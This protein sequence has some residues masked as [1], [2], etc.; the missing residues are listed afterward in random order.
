MGILWR[1]LGYALAQIRRRP[2]LY[3]GVIVSLAL[4]IG[5]N[6]TIFSYADALLLRL[7]AVSHP[8]SLAEVYTHNT[9]PNAA[10]GGLYPLSYLDYKDIRDLN[11]SFSGLAIYDPLAQV[12]M[13]HGEGAQGGPRTSWNLQLVSGN[14]FTVLGV[15]PILGRAILPQEA[16]TVGTSAV[17]VLAYRTW[18]EQFGG[19]RHILG[20]K[21][22]LNQ[23]PYI[24]VGVAPADFDGLISGVQTDAWAPV[25]MAVRTG[26]GGWLTRG[27][28]TMFGIG[29]LK[30]SVTLEQATADLTVVQKQLDR[31]YPNDDKPQFL[32]LATQFGAEPAFF[33]GQVAG[34]NLLLMAIVGLV[35]L[36]A[37]FNAANLLLV[38][39][40]NRRR[41][42][43]V[44]SALGA[45]RG[46]LLRQGLTES[47]LVA[48]IAGGLGLE[49]GLL[50]APVLL[51]LRPAGFP[52]NLQF[53]L[54]GHLAVFAA[55]LAL[56]TGIVFGIVPSWQAART[57]AAE[58]LK[59]STGGAAGAG[60]RLRNGLIAAQ[61]AMCMLILVG[62]GLCLRSLQHANA[63]NPGF[64]TD[65][66]L[67]AQ[68][69][70]AG[71][72]YQG[73]QARSYLENLE[74]AIARA[75]GVRSV[76]MATLMP[77]SMV[78][79]QREVLAA[80]M[81]PPQGHRG[82]PIDLAVVG[83]G[84]FAATGTRLLEGRDF[85]RSDLRPA[86]Q[87]P[88]SGSLV[89]QHP[90]FVVVNQAMAQAF[91][92]R[93]DALGRELLFPAGKAIYRA[94]VIGVAEN[95]K[96]RSLG[97]PTRKFM[98][99]LAPEQTGELLVRTASPAAAAEAGL[100][101]Q[102]MELD[103]NLTTANVQTARDGLNF[104][105]FPVRATSLILI[106]FGSLV[107]VLALVGLYG[108]IAGS[109][110]QRTREFGVRL[111]IGAAP[112]Q[113]LGEVLREGLRL[114]AWGLAAGL[115]LAALLGRAIAGLL[116]GISPLDPAA[117]LAAAAVL[118]AVAVAA[119]YGPARRAAAVDPVVALR[120]E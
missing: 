44:R 64:E 5:A 87:Q 115:L 40:H 86:A 106:G 102:L 24:V 28:R 31:T 77:L 16:E 70:A 109:V 119:A 63:I 20:E 120:C 72:G 58:G 81:Q 33:R 60:H 71:L 82:I 92:P 38:Q 98:Y 3:G 90:D 117:Y 114:A 68:V 22:L 2:L 62:A 69:D 99:E 103:P 42:W 19:D 13:S 47:L 29:R 107:L 18:Q 80:G 91:W 30:P 48:A 56:V 111:A 96:Y 74:D 49:C 32:G 61:V 75:P 26:Q 76:A 39:S 1:D 104:F 25:T 85:A 95:G 78:N 108:V 7:P 43:A 27:S 55:V 73:A 14:Y 66:L 34:A 45:S 97:E 11:H 17:V 21:V 116:Y 67:T 12:T 52:V 35:L 113:V 8:G 112:A 93:Q 41:E 23:L 4:G 88:S 9:D 79:S 15:H 51:R 37:C 94:K 36:I 46:R 110:A 50:A 10:F 100:R 65:H 89:P 105:L 84:Y 83:P 59:A 6:A 118:V 53:G 101:T 57:V 54:N